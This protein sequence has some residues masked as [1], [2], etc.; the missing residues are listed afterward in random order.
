MTQRGIVTH[1]HGEQITVTVAK[2]S[3]CGE[4]CAS[5]KGG[6]T[7]GTQ[8]VL[9]VNHTGEALSVGD[10]VQLETE[11]GRVLGISAAVYLVPLVCLFA[12][13]FIAQGF[14]KSELVC[15]LLSVAAL[16]ASLFGMRVLDRAVHKNRT[17]L[18][19]IT[20]ILH[21]TEG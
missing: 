4:S 20:E 6:C 8:Q 2:Q 12:S 21:K 9:A 11:T 18:V 1:I 15:A 14:T 19:R 17:L 5:C 7:P 10:S 3:M 13:Y 16:L